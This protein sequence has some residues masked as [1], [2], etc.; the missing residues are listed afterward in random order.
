MIK[1]YFKTAL[2]NLWRNKLYSFINIS[3][4][5][6]GLA[7]CMLIMLYVAHEYSFDRFHANADRI[8][9]VHSKFV[10]G[11]DTIQMPKMNYATATLV[12]NSDA[13]VTAS[14]R[15]YK[16]Y[17]PVVFQNPE[18]ENAKFS[19]SNLLYA[20]ANFFQFFSFKLV[21]GNSKVVLNLPF[22]VVISKDIARKYFGSQNPIGKT[23]K[24]T[25]DST[26]TFQVSGVMENSPSN[27][28]LNADFIVSISSLKPMG[29][30]ANFMQSQTIGGGGFITYFILK[31]SGDV[32]HVQQ[33]MQTLAEKSSQ[34]TKDRYILTALK[35]MHI[36]L[37]FDGTANIKYLQI[38]PL[39]AVLVLLLALVNYMSLSTARATIRAKEIGVRK[40]TGASRKTIALQFYLESALYAILSFV[41]AYL[42]VNLFQP[43]FFNMLQ[44]KV[45]TSFVYNPTVIGMMLI[46]L[47]ITII[48]AGSYPA[49]VLSAFKPVATLSG[50]MS[51]KKGGI[52]VRRT[53]TVLQ[54]VISVALII[55]GI[56]IDRQLYFMRHTA[57]GVNRE[58]V[59]T[60]PIQSTIGKHYQALRKD[61]QNLAG[62]KEIATAQYA[63]YGGYD[64]YF[65]KGNIS[66]PVFNM[67]KHF[68]STLGIK[69]KVPPFSLAEIV[70]PKKTLINEAAI[71]KLNLQGDP[72]G[73]L[74]DFGKSKYEIIGVVKNFNFQSLNAKI[75]GLALFVAP[76]T[77]SSFG[78][79]GNSGSCLFVKINP[80]TNLP[81]LV[82][83]I[84]NVYTK[85]DQ[86]TPFEYQFM[87][88]AFNKMFKAED[89]LANIFSLFIGL[90]VLI[91]CMGLFGLAAFTAQQR[92]KEIG[93]RKVM[94][95]SIPQIT[96]LLSKD[97]VVL[98]VLAILI[99]SPIA[100][101]AMQK[102]LQGFAYR[103]QIQW[104]M[105]ALAG[106]LAIVIA[107]LTISFQAV[108]AALA[109]PVKSLRSE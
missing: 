17:T 82:D 29:E 71:A 83:Q 9:S 4:L 69:W 38:F 55:C 52:W 46:L 30:A 88:E 47:I 99:A 19:E 105:F 12:K 6:L 72:V 35:D 57:T 68:I 3:G 22:Q 11:S 44:L 18:K 15:I 2:R 107:L 65:T 24:L 34:G 94:G 23:L 70:Q 93:I 7:I 32:A 40:V 50:K 36:K 86:Q 91:A 80:K 85:Y 26:Y 98:I 108:K 84:K 59:L 61:I 49:I 73:K 76:D 102:W 31:N 58:N 95:A 13:K 54:F 97:F 89:R 67:D 27:T 75:D 60:I 5:A 96:A 64:M 20:D 109:N 33:T 90:T 28:D 106:S 51:N 14:M 43:M 37:N 92:T 39:V 48:A 53:F 74:I 81:R 100:F 103:I 42:L 62:I 41:L 78:G 1:N 87:D 21:S 104:W 45:D 56:I 63:M 16:Q 66:L 77:T 10:M 79:I 101:F 8:F 25:G